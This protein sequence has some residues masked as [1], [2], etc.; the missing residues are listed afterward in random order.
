MATR[1]RKDYQGTTFVCDEHAQ[2]LIN[3][4]DSKC[5]NF[6]QHTA[7]A[8]DMDTDDHTRHIW[9]ET[10]DRDYYE[11]RGMYRMMQIAIPNCPSYAFLTMSNW[12]D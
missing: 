10:A 12:V 2:V 5:E 7:W 11:L 9:G 3:V 8:D 4:F 1:T 6:M